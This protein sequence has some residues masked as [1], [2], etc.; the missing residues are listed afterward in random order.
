MGRF[1][2]GLNQD[3]ADEVEVYDY[4]TMDD[5]LNLA[6]EAERQQ[7]RLTT[8]F[9]SISTRDSDGARFD[10]TTTLKVANLKT[11]HMDQPPMSNS[12]N[13]VF[14]SSKLTWDDFVE[15]VVSEDVVLE[16][17]KLQTVS[18]GISECKEDV[19][20]EKQKKQLRKEESETTSDCFSVMVSVE[21]PNVDRQEARQPA[22]YFNEHLHGGF[23]NKM[24]KK[25]LKLVATWN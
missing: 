24:Y 7:Q 16:E 20:Q 23:D 21:G 9:N 14:T 3:I 11:H 13:A 22:A 8:W 15:N 12:S 19:N 4:A 1:L 6:I 25:P 10:D 5:L 18:K 17:P 2:L